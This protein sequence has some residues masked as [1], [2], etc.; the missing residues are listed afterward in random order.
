MR[1]QPAAVWHHGFP[2]YNHILQLNNDGYSN[3][4]SLQAAF[5]VREFTG[6]TGQF[7]YVWSRTFDTGSANRGGDFLSDFQNPYDVSK[8]YAPSNF[9]TPWNVNFT[10]VYDVP[11]VHAVPEADGQKVGR[12]IRS[13]APRRDVHSPSYSQVGS[14][15]RIR[16]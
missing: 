10:L 9:D 6:L 2:D 1:Y 13:S 4:N 5:K 8:N 14:T 12:S 16:G 15:L 11:R 7:N 3:Y